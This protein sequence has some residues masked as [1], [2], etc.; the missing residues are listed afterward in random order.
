MTTVRQTAISA[1]V[2]I[3]SARSAFAAR[4]TLNFAGRHRLDLRAETSGHLA[5]VLTWH[6]QNAFEI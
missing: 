6:G 3:G 2:P 1:P 5:E 4:H